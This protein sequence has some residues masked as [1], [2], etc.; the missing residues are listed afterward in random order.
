LS[1]RAPWLVAPIAR[2]AS[3]RCIDCYFC[4]I[5]LIIVFIVVCLLLFYC[6]SLLSHTLAVVQRS[7][8][9]LHEPD[10]CVARVQCEPRDLRRALSGL[11]LGVHVL[12]VR[13]PP[14]ARLLLFALRGTMR[15]TMRT[16][17]YRYGCLCYLR[18]FNSHTYSSFLVCLSFPVLTA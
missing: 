10:A 5:L 12:H 17:R 6:K 14:P 1:C 4:E 18:Y 8:A 7:A 15:T 11:L 9:S 2:A 3:W 13:M 16:T